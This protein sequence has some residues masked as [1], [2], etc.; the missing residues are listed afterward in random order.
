MTDMGQ[1]FD[2]GDAAMPDLS[3]ETI[4]NS[5]HQHAGEG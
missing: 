3:Q 5:S 2:F 1:Y 4:P